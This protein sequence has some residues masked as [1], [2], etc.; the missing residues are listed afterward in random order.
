M[1][2]ILNSNQDGT[3]REDITL[4]ANQNFTTSGAGGGN[5]DGYLVKIVNNSGTANFA[6]PTATTDQAIFILAQSD[7]SGNYV[8][9]ESPGLDDECRLQCSGTVVPGGYLANNSAQ[10]G[11]VY[12]PASGAGTFV[13]DWIAEEAAT[14]TAAAP[15]LVKARRI[16]RYSV[17]F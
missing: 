8:A 16:A 2:V 4:A 12:T 13:C 11:T 9:A 5:C 1:N 7:V 3:K 15:V 17:T 14:G 10:Y 6:L